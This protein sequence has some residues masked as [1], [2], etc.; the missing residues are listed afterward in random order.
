METEKGSVKKVAM[1]YGLILGLVSVLLSVIVYALGQTYEQPWW[2]SL[3][4]FVIMLS[5]I[6]Y[7]LKAFKESNGGFLSL[8]EALKVGLA[9]A[10]IAGI[11][12]VLFNMLFVT[13][14]EPDFAANIVEKASSD[15][16]EQ[17]PNMTE[18][19]MEMAI[20]ITEK[21]VS[22]VVM[23]AMGII[24]SLFFGFIISLISGLI[25]KVEKPAHLE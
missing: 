22:P 13:V 14:I 18:D 7:A 16:V 25:M 1:Q 23:A 20:S 3:L 2:Q 21:M 15:M 10:L 4:S 5:C 6:I 9:T 8:G 17:N 11:I 12:G 19:Q 24:L